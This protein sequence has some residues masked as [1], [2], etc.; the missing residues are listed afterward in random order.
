M[1]DSAIVA[2]IHYLSFGLILASLIVERQT[3]KSELTITE[4]WK[5]LIA[6]GIYGT[7]ATAILA[8][9]V[10]RLLYFGKGTEFY[11]ENPVFWAKIILFFIVASISL[12]PT[13]SFLL[14]IGNLRQNIPPK[15]NP[16]RVKLIN[17][18][19]NLELLGFSSI[20][21]LASLMARGIGLN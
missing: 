8:T 6:D 10:L 17:W 15:L 16:F 1:W 2:Y 4:G 13:I 5:I 18:I 14:W 12:Y 11:T 3:V 9:G 21:L 7:A 20:P 19:I